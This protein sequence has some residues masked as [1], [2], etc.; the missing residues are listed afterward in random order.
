M[1]AKK[2]RDVRSSRFSVRFMKWMISRTSQWS[3]CASSSSSSASIAV[4]IAAGLED[5]G[6]DERLEQ[7]QPQQRVV[8]L[9]ERAERPELIARRRTIAVGRRRLSPPPGR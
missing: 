6:A 3:W 8:Q 9:A 5:D 7:A 4:L 1:S 2:L